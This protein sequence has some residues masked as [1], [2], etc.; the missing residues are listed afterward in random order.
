[1]YT[2]IHGGWDKVADQYV[3]DTRVL[4]N[5]QP[6]FAAYIKVKDLF[7]FSDRL[8]L[9]QDEW[10]FL[11]LWATLGIAGIAALTLVLL[12][13]IFGWRTIFSR[14]PGKLG[15]IVYFMCLGLGYIVVEVGLISHFMLAL[16]N[17]TVSASVL[18]TGMLVF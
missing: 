10:G 15:V 13:M 2:L 4:T 18:I 7:A 17:A 9:V 1:W 6:Y 8:E 14:Y 3:F 16:S 11:L 5:H 12:P